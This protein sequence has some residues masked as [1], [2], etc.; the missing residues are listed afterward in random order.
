MHKEIQDGTPCLQNAL[1]SSVLEV[2]VIKQVP[3]VWQLA[4]H[5][6]ALPWQ[7]IKQIFRLGFH[8]ATKFVG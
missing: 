5:L 4:P 8:S 6:Y 1:H 7:K 2:E 3:D